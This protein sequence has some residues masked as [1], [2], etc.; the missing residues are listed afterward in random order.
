MGLRWLCRTP[1]ESTPAP[2]KPSCFD[3][4]ADPGKLFPKPEN[5]PKERRSCLDRSVESPGSV[6]NCPHSDHLRRGVR[7]SWLS[8]GAKEIPVPCMFGQF[9]RFSCMF[10]WHFSCIIGW[11]FSCMVGQRFS[12]M[13]GW[14]CS[15]MWLL[16]SC[17][18]GWRFY[19]LWLV[20]D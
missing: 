13:F 17:M 4:E 19:D 7:A 9:W 8:V 10:R 15:C 2:H 20:L 16:F 11:R 6:K 12:C 18:F 14:H 1:S 5:T 3:N